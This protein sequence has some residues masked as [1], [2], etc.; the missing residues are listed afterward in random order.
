MKFESRRYFKQ[1]INDSRLLDRSFLERAALELPHA[2]ECFDEMPIVETK[3]S[4]I[5][6]K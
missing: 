2:F 1:A 4:A 3:T 6:M 5:P